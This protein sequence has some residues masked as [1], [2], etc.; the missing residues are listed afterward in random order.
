MRKITI[1]VFGVLAAG[2]A[3]FSQETQTRVV[4]EVVAVVNNDVIT[5]SRVRRESKSIVDSYVQ[6]GKKRDE[7]L[8]MVEEKQGELIANLIN[9][10]LMMQR[11]KDKGLDSDIEATINQRFAEIMKQNKMKTVEELYAAMEKGG[12]D[13]KDMRELWRKQVTRDQIL[14]R[15]VQGELY[16]S[17]KEKEL[18]DYYE[19][20][21]SK[22]TQP[23]TV[24]VSELFLGFAGRDVA[25]V[26]EKAAQ[27]YKQ[28]KAGG[29]FAQIVKDNGDSG[30]ITQGAGKF[31]KIR[32]SEVTEKLAAPLKGVNAG[33]YT[34]PFELDELG[35]AILRVDAREQAS[36]Q[37]VYNEAAVRNAMMLER[38]PE[39]QKKYMSKLREEAHIDINPSYRP[40]VAPILFADE[41]Q[42]KG[43]R[44][45]LTRSAIKRPPYLRQPFINGRGERI[46]TSDLTVPNRALYQTEPRPV[47]ELLSVGY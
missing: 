32:L 44:D 40:L 46:R 33:E 23:E 3:A 5:L 29:D 36:S 8:K 7:A 1:A 20:N 11:A 34:M 6:E 15:E 38:L 17:F 21:K 18:K 24:S 47:N 9:E 37:S 2:S 10:E 42:R 25:S 22:F 45:K 39:E 30:M 31:E 14:Q 28:L 12:V 13:P 43:K 26:R 19:K 27:L 4:D 16:W 41:R 35:M